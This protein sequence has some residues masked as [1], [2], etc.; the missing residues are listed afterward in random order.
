VGRRAVLCDAAGCAVEPAA[1]GEDAAQNHA[2]PG[3][4]VPAIAQLYSE[5]LVSTRIRLHQTGGQRA[6]SRQWLSG[7]VRG[8]RLRSVE[9]AFGSTVHRQRRG[10]ADFMDNLARA[11]S[12]LATGI[13]QPMGWF[14]YVVASDQWT[15]SESLYAMHGFEPGEV[16]ATTALFLAHK[17]P[18]DRAHTGKMLDQALAAGQ[19]FCCRHRIVDAQQNVRVVVC[20]GEGDVDPDGQVE[21]VH[22][23]FVDITD[24]SARARREEIT[25]AVNASAATRAN[26]EQAKGALMLAEGLTA[27]DAFEIL[28]SHSSQANVK[29]RDVAASITGAMSTPYREEETPNQRISRLLRLVVANMTTDHDARFKAL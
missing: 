15:W 24:A 9:A 22:G 18:E 10:E 14:K 29:L 12:A 7:S 6:E 17:H 21:V 20:I 3:R 25:A 27:D 8:S 19:P 2:S 5:K 23:Y 11:A 26:I 13:R 1:L 4:S 28:A 16:P